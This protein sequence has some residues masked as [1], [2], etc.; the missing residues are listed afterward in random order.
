MIRVGDFMIDG[1]ELNLFYG[2]IHMIVENSDVNTDWVEVASWRGDGNKKTESFA[3]PNKEWRIRWVKRS[4]S[5]RPGYITVFVHHAD[6]R[7]VGLAVNERVMESG[8]TY[9]EESGEFCLD[10]V[11]RRCEWEIVVE[12][13]RS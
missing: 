5:H 6:N 11:A 1:Y 13:R 2:N 10:I 4:T 3:I 12:K 7:L 9:M 8:E